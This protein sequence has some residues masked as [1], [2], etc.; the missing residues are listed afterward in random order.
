MKV[1]TT[2]L[3]DVIQQ[4]FAFS[5]DGRFSPAQQ[6]AFLADGKRLRGLLLNL[7]SAQFDDG[8]QAVLDA[9]SKLSDVNTELENDA[10]VLDKAATTLTNIAN[11]VSSLDK[12]LGVAASFL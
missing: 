3:A 9:N 1:D 11:L 6:A 5:S 4:C 2:T 8:T 7:L 10:E 12:L